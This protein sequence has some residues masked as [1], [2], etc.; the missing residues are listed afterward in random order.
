MKYKLQVME[1]ISAIGMQISSLKR[2]LKNNQ[3]SAQ[4]TVNKLQEFENKLKALNELI[5]LE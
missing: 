4:E 1:K 5:T 2:S 3:V